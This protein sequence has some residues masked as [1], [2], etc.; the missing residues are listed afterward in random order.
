MH[1]LREKKMNP[2]S[3]VV[4]D[5]RGNTVWVSIHGSDISSF[6]F[7]G[8]LSAKSLSARGSRLLF[9]TVKY[10]A[11]SYYESDCAERNMQDFIAVIVWIRYH[12]SRK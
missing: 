9:W 4:R 10:V 3:D 5:P 2:S 12:V 11:S 8:Y 7:N 6:H 1:F